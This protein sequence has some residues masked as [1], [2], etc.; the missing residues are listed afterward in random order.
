MNPSVYIRPL[1]VQDALISYQ[2]RNNPRIWR[3]TGARPDK[4]ITPEMETAWLFDVL[5]RENE[6][7]FAICLLMDNK[8]IGNIF[9]T[10]ILEGEAQMHIFIG[11]MEYWGKRRAYESICLI[12]DYGFNEL[13]L[14]TIYVQINSKNAAAIVLGKLVGFK[15]VSEYYDTNKEMMLE[16]MIFTRSRYEHQEHLSNASNEIDQL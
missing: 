2:W 6:R 11:E 16:K 8:Y 4:Y 3:F 10:D 5:R 13:I 15:K 1:V 14:D 12:F 7:R 9:L